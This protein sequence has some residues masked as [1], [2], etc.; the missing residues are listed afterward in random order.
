MSET[1]STVESSEPVVSEQ[2]QGM[3]SA[4]QRRAEQGRTRQR[5]SRQSRAQR[6]QSRLARP[7]KLHQQSEA[8]LQQLQPAGAQQQSVRHDILLVDLNNFATF[9]TLAV[10][11][12]VAALRN[13]GHRVSLMCPLSHDVPA[14]VREYRESRLDDIK[15]RLHLTT[16]PMLK[17]LRNVARSFYYWR[18]EK[19]HPRVIEH[20]RRELDK[21]PDVLLLS[22]YLQHYNTVVKIAALA[23][24]RGI[25]VLLGGPM[26]NINGT[27]EL[28]RTIPGISAV[29]GAEADT[30]I[31]NMVEELCS[32]SPAAG[33]DNTG[34]NGHID[35]HDY[36]VEESSGSNREK[37]ISV[38][39]VNRDNSQRLLRFDGVTLAT[40]DSSDL[41]APMRQL[42]N[43]PMPDYTDFPWD[44]YPV[45]IIPMMTGRGCQ[46]DKCRFCS[47]VVSVNGRTFR[48]RSVDNVLHEMQ[49]QARRH[50]TVSFVFLDLKLNS[51]PAMIRGIAGRIQQ[52]VQGAEWIGTVHVDQRKDN[53]LSAA[54]LNAAVRG[55]MRRVSFGLES[56]SQRLLDLMNKGCTVE[57]NSQFIREAH[58]AG[59]SIRCTMFKGYPGETA[60][61]MQQT[62]DFLEAHADYL[63]RVRFNEFSVMQGTPIYEAVVEKNGSVLSMVNDDTRRAKVQYRTTQGSDRMYQRAKARALDVVHEINRRELRISARQFDGIM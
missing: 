36:S 44:R 31:A 47:D 35:G 20:T 45:R 43:I 37:P 2:Q 59:L 28:W 51:Y 6:Q 12:L 40:G 3:S 60:E 4:I 19:P 48:T 25:P 46:W 22:A 24:A 14:A 52:L 29:V 18:D 56:G 1:A 58:A 17:Q 39:A 27:A 10:G 33:S 57:R 30:T 13:A 49:E 8:T 50:D 5:R 55:G 38:A 23:K 63:D 9:P 32:N 7:A 15:R 41:A 42:D 11:I 34:D 54:D 61:D 26:F 53:G 21:Q 62:A 16:S